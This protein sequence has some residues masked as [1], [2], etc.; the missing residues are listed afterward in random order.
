MQLSTD[1][2]KN[3]QYALMLFVLLIIIVTFIPKPAFT[4]TTINNILADKQYWI[5]NDWTS[6]ND[7]L[8]LSKKLKAYDGKQEFQGVIIDYQDDITLNEVTLQIRL[9]R[10]KDETKFPQQ[11]ILYKKDVDPKDCDKIFDWLKINFGEPKVKIDLSHDL[12][13]EGKTVW[14][15][16]IKK[17]TQWLL[18]NTHIN[19]ECSGVALKDRNLTFLTVQFNHKS[20]SKELKGLVPIKC[21]YHNEGLNKKQENIFIVNENDNS[22]YNESN[23]LLGGEHNITDETISFKY[24]KDS[25]YIEYTINR[26]TGKFEGEIIVQQS[27]EPIKS[28]LT[29]SCEKI[30]LKR[31]F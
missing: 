25:T 11:V 26:Y 13:I 31:K 3:G 1:H 17:Q 16:T 5:N 19:Y 30:D 15:N 2:P 21:E 9:R 14:G 12:K 29:G 6:D 18:G 8:W 7:K 23:R 22:L 4:E 28:N 27:P 20:K 10:V 24:K